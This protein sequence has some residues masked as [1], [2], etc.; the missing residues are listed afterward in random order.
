M[1]KYSNL[2][3]SIV[4][5]S[6]FIVNVC[7][8]ERERERERLVLGEFEL[9]REKR[10]KVEVRINVVWLDNLHSQQDQVPK[11]KLNRMQFLEFQLS[12]DRILI[13]RDMSLNTLTT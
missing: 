3:K 6:L 1:G 11:M 10:D 2:L 12:F 7:I 4:H 8:W 9:K 5:I 13:D